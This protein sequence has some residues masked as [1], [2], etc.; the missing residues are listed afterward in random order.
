MKIFPKCLVITAVAALSWTPAPALA[1][2]KKEAAR[3]PSVNNSNE[4]KKDDAGG[5]SDWF[6]F[7]RTYPLKEI[8][9]GALV[10]AFEQRKAVPEAGFSK[11]SP[12]VVTASPFAPAQK[13]FN[14]D[15]VAPGWGRMSG[16]TRDLAIDPAN[17]SRMFLATASGGVWRTLDGGATWVPKT[18]TQSSLSAS[19]V[20]IDPNNANT[21]YA[22]T[23]EGPA[24]AYYGVGILKSLDSGDSWTLTAGPFA[25]HAIADM[26]VDPA[27]SAKVLV[28][29]TTAQ[30]TPGGSIT[31]SATSVGVFRSP[32]SGATYPQVAGFTG[33]C[34]AMRADPAN[35]ANIYASKTG[36]GNPTD[37]I[38]KSSDRG[39][40]WAQLN[41]GGAP[42]QTAEL[43]IGI[44]G[45]GT[46]IYIGGKDSAAATKVWKSTDSG[47]NWTVLAAAPDYCEGQCG[48]DNGIAV[49]PL[50]ANIAYFGGV[51]MYRT[52]DGGTTW[53]QI[54][55]SNSSTTRPLH[56]DHHFVRYQ[57]G[58]STVLYDGND[59]GIYKTT[60]ANAVLPTWASLTGNSLAT[61]QPVFLSLHPTDAN[62]MLAGYQDNG[63]E[64]RSLGG[65][66]NWSERCGGDGA[67][68]MIDQTT[69]SIMYC[70]FAGSG[71]IGISKS[72]DSGTSFGTDVSVAIGAERRAFN[73]PVVMDP[74]TSTILYAGSQRLWHSVNGGLAWTAQ[75]T[76]PDLTGG[77][78]AKVTAIA[79]AK[80]DSTKIYVVT[81]DGK[82]Q[83][84][85]N[86]G[87][88]FTDTTKAPLPGRYATSVSVDPTNPAIAY[89]GYSGFN[90][91]TPAAPGHIF[92][93]A[94]S[95]T[96]WTNISGTL[97]DNPVNAIA[98]RPSAPAEIYA[99]SDVGFFLSLDSGG[100]W[101]KMTNGMPNA[102]IAD[103]EVNTTTD[104]LVVATYGRS[105]FSATLSSTTPV[106]LQRFEAE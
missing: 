4:E 23:G 104:L 62:I 67:S 24:G 106:V 45:T 63:T 1:A 46:T 57:Q 98:V 31:Y 14:S 17:S 97:P 103:I 101:A 81:G 71:N 48:F 54:G 9:K 53:Q 92:R 22:G 90:D 8:P 58:S 78:S 41:T 25:R 37:G 2:K 65:G 10:R 5:A 61:L 72:I 44:S 43:A 18:D 83:F 91:G 12:L 84:S 30:H 64:L 80:S 20:V 21:V 102:A 94:D 93:T 35:F 28:C 95:G 29:S 66:T 68:A 74:N 26:L 59:G 96:T 87:V 70:S 100:T 33:V 36:D 50:N 69:P 89:V 85:S 73:P 32:D 79:V 55:D 15:N 40:T 13:G 11:L 42:T 38:W 6:L 34:N 56:V 52:T 76:S 47:A 16:R 49:D 51:P 99:G 75:S 39:A 86:S 77:G 19:A 88:T 7:Q 105:I 60:D 27:D 82:V 3:A